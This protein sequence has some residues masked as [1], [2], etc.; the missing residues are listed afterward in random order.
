MLLD[1]FR[2]PYCVDARLTEADAVQ[3]RATATGP[4]LLWPGRVSRVPIGSTI[5]GREPGA[6]IQVFARVVPDDQMGELLGRFGRGWRTVRV[7]RGRTGHVVGSI[8]RDESGNVC[9][10]FDPDDVIVNFWS[11]RYQDIADT[12][13]K[14]RL[15]RLLLL[16]Y[17][18]LR[19]FLPRQVQIWLRRWL[20]RLQARP[21]FPRWPV[22]TSLHDFFDLMFAMLGEVAG[23]AVPRIAAWPDGHVWAL[24]LTH[25]VERAE[26]L[27]GLDP[28]LE[29]ERAHGLRS[30]WNLVS[31]DYEVPPARLAEI[32]AHGCEVGVHGM[33]HDGR[34]LES[35]NTWSERLPLIQDA[36]ALWGADGFRSPALHR[37]WEWMRMLRFQY[38]SSSPDTDPFEPQRGGCCSWLP[39]FNGEILELPITLQQDHTLFVILG[40]KDETA[41]VQK[42]EFLREQGGLALIN[43]HPDYL[44]VDDRMLRAYS[45]LVERYASDETAWK[46]LPREVNAWWRERAASRLEREGDGWRVVGPAAQ[47][48]RVELCARTW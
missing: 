21:S 48:A 34:D 44:V 23:E 22:E 29:L 1:H 28:V 38:D 25:D 2:V 41:W 5:E 26:G 42:A 7:L 11:E 20:A 14:R 9:L 12:P 24:V 33:H 27:A 36:A 10:P 35:L 19:P 8:W 13:H 15:R 16:S 18:R 45:R 30:S 39:F 17:Y 43:T 47:T 3:L 40:R 4:V 31:C 32:T 37:R 46:A 6:G